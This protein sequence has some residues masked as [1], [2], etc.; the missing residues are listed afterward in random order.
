MS[1]LQSVARRGQEQ[2]KEPGQDQE[3]KQEP[4]QEKRK[5]PGRQQELCKR[6]E[7][8]AETSVPTCVTNGGN[9]LTHDLNPP[10]SPLPPQWLL[11]PRRRERRGSRGD[12]AYKE[13]TRIINYCLYENK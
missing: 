12:Q 3:K 10:P 7:A 11:K 4:G 5:E 2:G 1:D 9:G 8:G 6:T 13:G